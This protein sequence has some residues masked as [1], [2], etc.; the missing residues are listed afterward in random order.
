MLR[1]VTLYMRMVGQGLLTHMQELRA[2]N[3]R[4]IARARGRAPDYIDEAGYDLIVVP[5][6]RDRAERQPE[7]QGVHE[8]RLQEAGWWDSSSS[9]SP[10][11]EGRLCHACLR[12]LRG[13]A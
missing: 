10:C 11:G 9:S 7:V 4:C 3:A 2:E 8:E 12:V 6:G 13:K 1:V 5:P